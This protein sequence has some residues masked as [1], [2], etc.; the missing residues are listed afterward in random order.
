MMQ[1]T[2]FTVASEAYQD[3]AELCVP[4]WRQNSGA[5]SV[6]VS[7]Y[8]DATTGDQNTRW[9]EAITTRADLWLGAIRQAVDAKT[10]VVLMDVDC[11]VRR[12]IAGGFDGEHPIAAV[13]WPNPQLSV[14]FLDTRLQWPFVDF[15][16]DFTARIKSI[17]E[18][19]W[20]LDT[21]QLIMQEK[22]LGCEAAVNKL[23][24]AGW[25]LTFCKGNGPE[26]L[27]AYP[28]ARV[29]H[30]HWSIFRE[31]ATPDTV[32]R[33]LTPLIPEAFCR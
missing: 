14:V 23:S 4:S 29:I 27:A 2:M 10:P 21:D 28:D 6:T 17:P 1:F 7:A 31:C 22:L 16:E 3:V 30:L 15:F 32:R 5:S 20:R 18:R 33:Q 25:G 9:R 19:Q 12:S 11:L 8:K 13:R 24:P 26:R